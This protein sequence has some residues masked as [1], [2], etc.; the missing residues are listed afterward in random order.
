MKVMCW[1]GWE[2]CLSV[3]P[4][5]PAHGGF[6]NRGFPTGPCHHFLNCTEG[7]Q[8][9]GAHS[10]RASVPNFVSLRPRKEPFAFYGPSW[11][12]QRKSQTYSCVFFSLRQESGFTLFRK[13]LL[14]KRWE[15]GRLAD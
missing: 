11:N 4:V 15:H 10:A 12:Q 3:L 5:R 1:V 13:V 8:A 2:S 7:A 14:Q 6:A 9:A